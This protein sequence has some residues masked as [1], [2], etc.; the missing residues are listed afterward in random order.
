MSVV[1]DG[2]KVVGGELQED[3]VAEP[4]SLTIM[5]TIRDCKISTTFNYN[6]VKEVPELN[7]PALVRVHS[8]GVPSVASVT[9]SSSVTGRSE[10]RKISRAEPCF[11]TKQPSYCLQRVHF[12]NVVRKD[13]LLKI[14]IVSEPFL[15]GSR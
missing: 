11:V 2:E 7:L 9:T 13:K 12:V 14:D 1:V 4:E 5:A 15:L 3:L 6:K 10:S 8:C